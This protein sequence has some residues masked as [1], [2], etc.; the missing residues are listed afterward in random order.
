M[1]I[2]I[3]GTMGTS[4]KI[5]AWIKQCLDQYGNCACGR[6]ITKKFGKDKLLEALEKEGYPCNLE[7]LSDI[8]DKNA[9]PKDGTYIV[10]LK[11][12]QQLFEEE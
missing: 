9:Y 1:I 3:G 6:A 10:S 12:R 4:V 7:I 2:F 5:P 8:K 11:N